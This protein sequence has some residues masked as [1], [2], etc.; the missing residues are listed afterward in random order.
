[1]VCASVQYVLDESVGYGA[2]VASNQNVSVIDYIPPPPIPS[3]PPGS[4]K[5]KDRTLLATS[6][7]AS[8]TTAAATAPV[9]KTPAERVA[10]AVAAK[11]AR[12][13]A[14]KAMEPSTPAVKALVQAQGGLGDEGIQD[15]YTP[16]PTSMDELAL[17]VSTPSATGLRFK[18]VTGNTS[19]GVFPTKVS[20][21]ALSR[22]GAL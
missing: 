5:S 14:R 16:P 10:A 6:S 1:M 19:Y 18:L 11:V 22:S 7:H 20:C 3:T 12:R 15:W 2:G 4:P 8:A 17:I 13:A 21:T 9:P